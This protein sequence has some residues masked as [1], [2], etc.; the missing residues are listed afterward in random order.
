MAVSRW[1]VRLDETGWGDTSL[2]LPDGDWDDRLTGRRHTG[3][4]AVGEV[5][6]DLPV[7]LLVRAH[8]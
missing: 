7:T 8:D 6:T 2:D 4:V 1:T 3:A 5:F